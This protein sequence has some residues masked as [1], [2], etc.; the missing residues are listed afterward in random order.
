MSNAMSQSKSRWKGAMLAAVSAAALVPAAT[1]AATGSLKVSLSLSPLGG[2][3]PK[4]TEYIA[5]TGTDKVYVYATVTGSS[6]IS[7]S[8]ID[9]L[10]YLYYNVNQAFTTAGTGSIT[11]ATPNVVPGLLN[12]NANGAQGGTLHATGAIAV[13]GTTLT[14]FAKPRSG[15]ATYS[16]LAADGINVIKSGNSVSF[17]VETLT[18][19]PSFTAKPAVAGTADSTT[20]SLSIPAAANTNPYFQANYFTDLTTQPATGLS[21]GAANT[22]NTNYT[23][24]GPVTLINAEQGDVNLDGRVNGSDAAIISAAFN[25]ATTG[26]TNGDITGDGRVNGSDSALVSANFNIQYSTIAPAVV[27]ASPTAQIAGTSSVPEPATSGL[28]AVAGLVLSLKKRST[29]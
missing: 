3:S 29:K 10:E 5:P 4:T 8:E 13:G 25:T 6:A 19:T 16:T 12:F 20:L 2:T 21:P 14:D 15:G 17:L 24:G 18:Y 11:A 26:Y 23:T 22:F 7:S 28:L 27:I 1:Q 9:G